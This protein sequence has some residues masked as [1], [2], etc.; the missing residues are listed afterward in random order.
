[1]KKRRVF[2]GSSSEY[3][4]EVARIKQLLDSDFIECVL[5]TSV[6]QPGYLTFEALEKMLLDCGAAVFL[7][8]PDDEAEIRQE[9][10][11]TPRA[12]VM[13]EFGLVAGR[14][15]R[16]NI[17]V[18]RYTN[19]KM[20][21]DLQGL[22]VIEM[23]RQGRREG[24]P[25][26]AG[27]SASGAGPS[28]AENALI[29]WASQLFLTVDGVARTDIVHGYTGQWNFDLDLSDWRGVTV[30]APSYVHGNGRLQIYIDAGG[31]L[32]SGLISGSL[33]FA[34]FA[35]GE[36]RSTDPIY[37]GEVRICHGVNT[38]TCDYD[39][40]MRFTSRTFALQKVT[41]MGTPPGGLGSLA[42]PQQPWLFSWDFRV[43]DE[44]RTL[45]GTVTANNPGATRGTVRITKAV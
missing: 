40:G 29:A 21:S 22:T 3:L 41:S 23:G 42:D 24:D 26:S 8:T 33:T 9:K 12:N 38:L 5:W 1:M 6:F 43:T 11:A 10:V 14:L 31:V 20:P 28:T 37:M 17:A 30:T 39:G 13:L 19:A 7:A 34:F 25:V 16:H 2:I 4:A 35:A 44:P 27:N 15:G 18:C 36:T 32:G 45:E